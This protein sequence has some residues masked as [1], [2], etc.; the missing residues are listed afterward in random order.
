MRVF[1]ATHWVELRDLMG[2][3]LS[4]WK[5]KKVGKGGR[6]LHLQFGIHVLIFFGLVDKNHFEMKDVWS[7]RELG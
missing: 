4:E 1:S 2:P 5:V 3:E 6:I 7:F